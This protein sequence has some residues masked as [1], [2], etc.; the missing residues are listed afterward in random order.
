[1]NPW[2]IGTEMEPSRSIRTMFEAVRRG[3][4]FT[5]FAL[6]LLGS[7]IEEIFNSQLNFYE[8]YIL[9]GYGDGWLDEF[10]PT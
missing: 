1:M 6:C 9:Y 3:R 5:Q 7:A 4:Q 8:H 2:F 10:A